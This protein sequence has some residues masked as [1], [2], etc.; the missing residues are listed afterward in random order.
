M[1]HRV[2]IEPSQHSF[3]AEPGETL[4]DAALRAGLTLPYG[5]RNGACGVCKGKVLSGTVD[6]GNALPHALPEEEKA[7]GAALF[8]CAKARSD[9]VIEAREVKAAGEIP[10]RTLPCR[11]E[12]LERAADDVL[13]LRLRLPANER[14]Q[15]LAGQ[16]VDILL[17]DGQRR[18]FSL[19][20]AP[21]ADEL[22]E[23]HIR[24]LPGGRFTDWAF[25]EMKVKD[26][27]RFEGPHG[28]FTL[29]EESDRP[30]I[31]L[32]SGTG[33]APIKALVEHAF[34]E[35]I[36]RDMVLYWGGRREKDLYLK[37]L[38]ERWAAEHPHFAFIPVLSEAE[39][40]WT[41]RTGLVHQAV[42]DDFADLSGHEVYACGAPPMVEVAHRSF[43]AERGLPEGA[44]Y[45]DAFYVAAKP[46]A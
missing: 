45:S 23:L 32:A 46:T 16:Y 7:A 11:V 17:K 3:T 20:I 33:F 40:G 44:F 10:V 9:L 8:C 39:A 26:I 31:L 36:R 27:L 14:L 13:I 15:F 2:V 24:H 1:S 22:L 29:N 38:A 35:G 28:S 5:C 21:H 12:S 25:N 18:S 43:I 37:S 34:H 6:H 4:L 42:L 30:L 19:A 41:G